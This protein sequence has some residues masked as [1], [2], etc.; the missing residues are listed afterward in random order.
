MDNE[1]KI[2][3][4]NE[5]LTSLIRSNLCCH[6]G[7]TITQESINEITE[8]IIESINYFLNKKDQ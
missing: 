1:I 4:N 6:I 3:I 7:K 2:M 8:Q 5:S